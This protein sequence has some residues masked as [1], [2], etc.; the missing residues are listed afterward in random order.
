MFDFLDSANNTPEQQN[1]KKSALKLNVKEVNQEQQTGIINDYEVTLDGCTCRD[2]FVRRLPCKHMY[3]LAHEL[4]IINLGGKVEN[5][6]DMK[7]NKEERAERQAVYDKAFS[8]SENARLLLYQITRAECFVDR[9]KEIDALVSELLASGLIELRQPTEKELYS[10]ITL[11]N[12]RAVVPGVPAGKKA[13]IISFLRVKC[14]EYEKSLINEF[15][16]KCYILNLA[17]NIE[18]YRIGLQRNITPYKGV[19]HSYIF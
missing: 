7:N 3:R 16:E 10:K 11:K 1:R 17:A 15:N 4:G 18:K 2:W 19:E 6:K 12:L 5:C 14:P 8:L 13:E 9:S